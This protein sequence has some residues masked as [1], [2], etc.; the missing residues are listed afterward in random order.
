MAPSPLFRAR[1]QRAVW[2]CC[3]GVV[4]V[5]LL[6]ACG[7]RKGRVPRALTTEVYLWQQ[8]WREAVGDAAQA[9]GKEMDALAV[10]ASVVTFPARSSK[11]GPKTQTVA[12]PWELFHKLGRPVALVVRLGAPSAAFSAGRVDAEHRVLEAAVARA[13]EESGKAGVTASE[14]QI[15]FDCP[16]RKLAAYEEIMRRL[17]TRWPRRKWS[18][19]ALPSWLK[20]DGFK[21]LVQ[22]TGGFILQV[23]S[24]KLPAPGRGVLLCEEESSK[25]WAEQAASAGVP[26]RI[27]LPTYRSEVLYDE[28]GKVLD[29]ISEDA[30]N[31]VAHRAASRSA[32][33]SDPEV[34]TRLV[35]HWKAEPPDHLTGLIWFR[36]PVKGD[37][38]NWPMTTF[39]K[40]VR[41]ELPSSRLEAMAEEDASGVW[42]VSVT[43]TGDGP[44]RWPK[45]VDVSLPRGSAVEAADARPGYLMKARDGGVRFELSPEAAALM[46]EMDS[47]EPLY[48]GWL[49][50]G[51]GAKP[52]AAAFKQAAAP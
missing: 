25:H 22:T 19:T 9:A 52:E 38:R 3:A 8:Q 34:M 50:T 1:L 2:R 6:A 12:V 16:E 36:L 42:R 7:G 47:Q 11:D 18:I 41:G 51:Q 15:D 46:P 33:V 44:V 24:L 21:G 10:L 48:I 4:A 26:F 32:A 29:V 20:A 17:K 14:V 27:A 23:H 30:P 39:L 40:V 28:S 35:Q 43:M 37:R 49:R 5:C 13:L 31:P 45:Q